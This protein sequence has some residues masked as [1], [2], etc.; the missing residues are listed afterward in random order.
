MIEDS[1]TEQLVESFHFLSA[2]L[3]S[4]IN[5]TRPPKQAA[6]QQ[7]IMNLIN[8]IVQKVPPVNL[9]TGISDMKW[10]VTN[11]TWIINDLYQP[12]LHRLR[13]VKQYFVHYFTEVHLSGI[14]PLF[15]DTQH[16]TTMKLSLQLMELETDAAYQNALRAH[17]KK[18][19]IMHAPFSD[20]HSFKKHRNSKMILTQAIVDI[21]DE[22]N[23]T[24]DATHEQLLVSFSKLFL[25]IEGF[26]MKR[27]IDGQFICEY[28]LSKP[29]LSPFLLLA[30]VNHIPQNCYLFNLLIPYQLSLQSTSDDLAPNI[31]NSTYP[32]VD[33][34]DDYELSKV[35]DA[36]PQILVNYFLSPSV[37][38][39]E[40][41]SITDDQ[42]FIVKIHTHVC[43]IYDKMKSIMEV[44]QKRLIRPICIAATYGQILTIVVTS[45]LK[46]IVDGY[47]KNLFDSSLMH[48]FQTAF[49]LLLP[50]HYDQIV[51]K[52][53]NVNIPDRLQAE[54][55]LRSILGFGSN[56]MS[57]KFA[58]TFLVPYCVRAANKDDDLLV[59]ARTV[60]SRALN[61]CE[62][63]ITNDLLSLMQTCTDPFILLDFLEAT[64]RLGTVKSLEEQKRLDDL[65]NN[66]IS[67]LPFTLMLRNDAPS[68]V[69]ITGIKEPLSEFKCFPSVEKIIAQY[70]KL[71]D[72]EYV[73]NPH[74]LA[75]RL[76]SLA[77]DGGKNGYDFSDKITKSL[78]DFLNNGND[79]ASPKD[80]FSVPVKI[81]AV[82]V[83]QNVI[84][85][86]LLLQKYNQAYILL[87]AL[88]PFLTTE[89]SS[90][91]WLY[92][93]VVA[94]YSLLCRI[95]SD[96]TKNFL[97]NIVKEQPGSL[98]YF[99]QNP[100]ECINRLLRIE[101]GYL[102]FSDTMCGEYSS[103]FEH[104]MHFSVCGILLSDQN[105][106]EIVESLL[107][108]AL[109]F[110]T[111][112]ENRE[113]ACVIASKIAARLPNPI[114]FAY[115]F[116]LFCKQASLFI[117]RAARI[118]VGLCKIEVFNQIC[119]NC[120]KF[121][122]KDS[123]RLSLFMKSVIPSFSRLKSNEDIAATMIC[124]LLKSLTN[125]S[126]KYQQE[127]VIDA[128][129]L[130]Y[131]S[132]NLQSKRKVIISAPHNEPN[133]PQ[134][135]KEI[136]PMCL[137]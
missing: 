92:K 10:G 9:I 40:F 46:T 78:I 131:I 70:K 88:T 25:Y 24:R 132:L 134:E 95:P 7:M 36:M 64:D 59:I 45:V 18:L 52:F 41:G 20:F 8:I 22:L 65:R 100:I 28:I 125:E 133:F 89:K 85:R 120:E 33:L 75:I 61:Y 110:N 97:L 122:A 38:T 11:L 108:P 14:M 86:F 58:M 16:D 60:I 116:G 93:F 96:D 72:N 55:L 62:F 123:D 49:S 21:L 73:E 117:V 114:A 42:D 109:N 57:N 77:Y 76:L 26:A 2:W 17:F 54:L 35:I 43:T 98:L 29:F 68:P 84:A 56:L 51:N 102:R 83:T 128:V 32:M 105:K 3:S 44:A 106:K 124:A 121:I 69:F 111:D 34:C 130:L 53:L 66:M 115:F 5:K 87:Q 47:D 67:R 104:C 1:T 112:F 137:I 101:S 30:M 74:L 99:S 19:I 15:E 6:T 23:T 107:Q 50:T 135:L 118:F 80:Q 94:N 126:P 113:E 48:F 82:S 4:N 90:L 136:I 63:Y 31:I 103:S 127:E 81:A 39:E 91:H 79:I 71:V 129:V 13:K 12:V 37:K 27:E 119:K